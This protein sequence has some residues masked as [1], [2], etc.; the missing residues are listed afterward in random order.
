[1][2]IDLPDSPRMRLTLLLPGLATLLLAAACRSNGPSGPALH[3]PVA[4]ATSSCAPADGPAVALLLA[5]AT[6]LAAAPV[7]PLVHVIVFRSRSALA[8]HSLELTPD[9]GAAS[10]QRGPDA[11]LQQA[12]TARLTVD[13]VAADG[14]VTGV[15]QLR[16]PD[17]SRVSQRFRAPW[18]ERPALCG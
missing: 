15:V 12:T 8:G 7:P 1:M 16:F 4:E 11:P 13:A 18:R 10:L 17:G 3:L 2:G 9:V 5:T 14:T 6:D